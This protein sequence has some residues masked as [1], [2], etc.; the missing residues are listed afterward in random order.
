M[1]SRHTDE[2]YEQQLRSLKEMILRMGAD[3]E[4][5][6]VRAI[7]SLVK[8]D[9]NLAREVILSDKDVNKLEL[10]V[11]D[12]CLMVLALHQPAASDLR[13]VTI[14]LKISTDLERIGD[15]AVNICEQVLELNKQE[16]LKPYKDLPLMAEKAEAMVRTALDAF[17]KGEPK[18]AQDVIES[19]DEVD[20][21]ETTIF[22]ELMGI[23]E[24]DSEAV[25]R[26]MRLIIISRHLERV[27]DHATNIA[28]EVNFLVK[29]E[30]I[31]H[32]G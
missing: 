17:I 5:M 28:E 1:A 4:S 24:K 27:A 22:E 2:N 23:M 3:V 12:L 8:R 26:A 20:G 6:I 13:F 16:P 31:R 32:S 21:L 18:L 11:D 10:E 30:D 9:S 14:G 25:S 15:L 7:N 29:G 19:D